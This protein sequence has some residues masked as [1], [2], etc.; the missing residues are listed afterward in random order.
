MELW[1]LPKE[2]SWDPAGSL[3]HGAWDVLF[4]GGLR[5]QAA[6]MPT[7]WKKKTMSWQGWSPPCPAL[8]PPAP[9]PCGSRK[10]DSGGGCCPSLSLSTLASAAL[11]G[12]GERLWTLGLGVSPGRRE[13]R[14]A[15]TL[16]K[17]GRG[18][19]RPPQRMVGLGPRE[20]LLCAVYCL[21]AC[22][23]LTGISDPVTVKTSGSRFGSWMTD[24]LAP[25]GDNRVSASSAGPGCEGAAVTR[26]TSELG[27]HPLNVW[28]SC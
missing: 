7:A 6:A 14:A 10:G 27:L 20:S 18:T 26:G 17:A 21:P 11:F 8:A 23:K 1:V 22:G 2:V 25:E 5:A 16:T 19:P 24:P 3:T 12:A 28:P 13:A 9:S 15:D 4:P